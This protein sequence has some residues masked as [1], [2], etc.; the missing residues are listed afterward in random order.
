MKILSLINIKGVS[1]CLIAY[2][3]VRLKGFLGCFIVGVRVL[4]VCR[5]YYR[6]CFSCLCKNVSPFGHLKINT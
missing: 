6:V 5:G 2:G 3:V 1:E 4:G